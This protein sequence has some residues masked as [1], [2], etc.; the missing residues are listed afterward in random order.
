MMEFFIKGQPKKK[1]YLNKDFI[2]CNMEN[3]DIEKE[4]NI[5]SMKLF[6]SNA[7]K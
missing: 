1:Q 4:R 7:K 3:K 5:E 2:I 6:T